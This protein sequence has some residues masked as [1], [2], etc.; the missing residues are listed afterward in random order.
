[1]DTSTHRLPEPDRLERIVTLVDAA[2]APRGWYG[3]HLLVKVEQLD[4]GDVELGL[5]ELPHHAHPMSALLGFVAPESWVAMGAVV[6]GW[7]APM[8]NVRPS[9]HRNRRRVRC[10]ALVD[11]SGR[12]AVTTSMDDGAVID[13]P[14]EGRMSDALKRCMG[15]AT[16]PPPPVSELADALWLESVLDAAAEQAV[17]AFTWEHAMN[18]RPT[19]EDTITT[20]WPR[21]REMAA[22]S[23]VWGDLATWMD[24]GMFARWMLGER[25]SVGDLLRQVD[26]RLPRPVA[27]RI[28]AELGR[29]RP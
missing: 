27:R 11:R 8:A 15:A 12:E 3:P 6:Y 4:D 5:R 10:T 2:I 20:S 26:A 28:R 13:S 9:R 29:P 14:G 7:A 22:R 24:D 19:D 21:L 16:A 18:L 1:M 25:P 17:G 23:G